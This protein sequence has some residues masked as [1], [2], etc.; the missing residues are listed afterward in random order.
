MEDI[1]VAI[2]RWFHLTATVLWIGLA[3]NTALV[4]QPLFRDKVSSESKGAYLEAMLS[5]IR[6][7]TWIAVITFAITGF[8]I[9]V[10][11]NNFEGF[12]NYFANSWTEIITFKH[13]V[14]FGMV[15]LAVY[16]LNGILPKLIQALKT[17]SPK[18]ARLST[19]NQNVT[20]WLA[21]LGILVLLL[22][23]IAETAGKA[24]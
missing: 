7:L 16:Q 1:F 6:P 5:K 15:F 14:V 21:A 11:S 12:S 19:L 24:S 4:F 8:I 22:T 18:T 20:L 23:A 2:L 17:S 10:L 3:V 13:V 9:M